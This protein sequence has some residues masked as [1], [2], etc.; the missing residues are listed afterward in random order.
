MYGYI[1]IIYDMWYI[2]NWI[3]EYRGDF[4][5]RNVYPDCDFEYITLFQNWN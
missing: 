5:M 1:W 4:V 2:N 3:K